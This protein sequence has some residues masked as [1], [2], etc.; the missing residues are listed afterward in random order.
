MFNLGQ[1]CQN[2]NAKI[3]KPTYC[4]QPVLCSLFFSQS[5]CALYGNFIIIKNKIDYVEDIDYMAGQR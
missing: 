1:I 3:R 5:E 2:S 4:H